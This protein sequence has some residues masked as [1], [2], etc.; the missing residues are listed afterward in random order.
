MKSLVEIGAVKLAKIKKQA[1]ELLPND[2]SW[3]CESSYK[4]SESLMI[5]LASEFSSYSDS[6]VRDIK[7]FL[8]T[9]LRFAEPL[10]V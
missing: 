6:L 10:C 3:F 4:N 8:A 1:V 7:N 9:S 5:K 2:E